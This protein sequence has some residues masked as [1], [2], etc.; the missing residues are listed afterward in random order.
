[1]DRARDPGRSMLDARATGELEDFSS[2]PAHP[3]LVGV[4]PSL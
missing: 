1:M 3:A 4:I 2:W